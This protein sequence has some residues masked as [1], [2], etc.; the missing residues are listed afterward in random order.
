[1][2]ETRISWTIR[3]ASL[4]AA[5]FILWESPL[6]VPLRVLII[7]FHEIFHAAAAFVTGGGVNGIEITLYK[8]GLTSLYGGIPVVVFS[9]GYVG[10]ALLGSMLIISTHR[11]PFKRPLYFVLGTILLLATILFARNPFGLA[12]GWTAG[13]FFLMIVFTDLRFSDIVTELVGITCVVDG[14]RDLIS[15]YWRRSGNDAA[16]LQQ[17]TGVPYDFIVTT[18]ILVSIILVGVAIAFTLK[19]ISPGNFEELLQIDRKS[20][21]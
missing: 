2:F 14:F 1:M 17:L 16:F 11:H 13:L 21:V 4:A 9:A 6:L 5:L 20:V 15:F 3:I 19:S 8:T 10:T 7:F 18:W 12:Y